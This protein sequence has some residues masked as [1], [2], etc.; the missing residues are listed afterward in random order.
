MSTELIKLK[1]KSEASKGR[2]AQE[3]LFHFLF[4]CEKLDASIFEPMIEEDQYFEEMDKYRFL[5]S[6]KEQFVWAK[7]RGAQNIHIKRGKC[8]MC[9]KGADTYEFYGNKSNP[10][11]AYVVNY[12]DGKIN[13]I[14]LCNWSSG[15]KS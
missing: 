9:K 2:K 11:F 1:V 15:T 6:L 13:D 3:V 4:A 12:D 14:F 5:A 10:E 8:Q 7:N